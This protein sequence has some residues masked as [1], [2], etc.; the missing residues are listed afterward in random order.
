MCVGVYNVHV[1]VIH[2]AISFVQRFFKYL[3]IAAKV[4][5]VIRLAKRGLADGKCVVIGLQSTGEA[6]TLEQLEQCDGEL[7]GFISTAK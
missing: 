3:C 2:F 4:P 1:H 5:E 7:S 6:R